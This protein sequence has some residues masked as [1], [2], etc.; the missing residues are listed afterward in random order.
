MRSITDIEYSSYGSDT[1]LDLHLPDGDFNAVFMYMHGGGIEKGDKEKNRIIFEYLTSHGIAAASI[2][3]RMYPNAKF[4]EY[5]EDAATAAAWLKNHIGEYGNCDKIYL[6]GS[7]AG[8]YISMMLCFDTKYLAAHGFKPTDFAG[9][10]HD[11]GQPTAHF[12]I[13]AKEYGVNRNRIIV[14]HTAPLYY[15]G[16]DKEYPPMYIIVS[17][18]DM[19]NRYEQTMLLLSTLKHFE[20]DESKIKFTLMH[21][22]HCA[23]VGKAD[24]KGESIFGRMIC[25]FITETEKA[26]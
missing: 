21:G 17:D 9:F 19:K 8:G 20:Y 26:E 2:N 6:G 25:D 16:I 4:P 15:I 12:N 14:D 1:S 23:Y 11:A 24:E 7:S 10:V 5:I 22:T 3:Y 18:N 13:I